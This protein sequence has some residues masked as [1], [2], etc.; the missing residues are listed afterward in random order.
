MRVDRNI[1]LFVSVFFVLSCAGSHPVSMAATVATPGAPAMA[2]P[3]Y[4][5][6]RETNIAV[7]E[8]GP[9]KGGGTTTAY[10]FFSHADGFKLALRKRALH[11]GSAIGYH[12]QDI[13]EVYYVL[14]GTG[15]M[16]INDRSFTVSAGDAILTRPGSSHGLKQS[17]KDDLVI[18]INYE[19]NTPQKR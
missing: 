19:L 16:T 9:H 6:E 13:D 4:V 17:G 7:N 2:E 11:P 14:S 18:L 10:P 3:G 12:L 8:P 15:I 1:F 5:L